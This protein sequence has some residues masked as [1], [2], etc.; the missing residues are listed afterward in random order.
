MYVYFFCSHFKRS[1]LF[2]ALNIQISSA[3][4]SRCSKQSQIN[5]RNPFSERFHKTTFPTNYKSFSSHNH[6]KG[7]FTSF[8]GGG[9]GAPVW[10]SSANFLHFHFSIYLGWPQHSLSRTIVCSEQIARLLCWVRFS[11]RQVQVRNE[12]YSIKLTLVITFLTLPLPVFS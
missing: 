8:A 7:S 10:K 4:L 3:K 11:V 12:T 9:G 5:Y 1:I 2:R 6:P